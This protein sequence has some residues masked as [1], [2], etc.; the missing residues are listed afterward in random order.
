N[1]SKVI[2]SVER[3]GFVSRARCK[4]DKRQM[5]FSLT[6]AGSDRLAAM[7]CEEID[8]SAFQF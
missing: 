2:A 7:Q 8:L 3:L 4:Q 1:A 5:Y 6:A